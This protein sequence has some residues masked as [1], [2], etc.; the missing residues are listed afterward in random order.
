MG[1]KTVPSRC[2]INITRRLRRLR[3]GLWGERLD[4]SKRQQQQTEGGWIH[5]AEKRTYLLAVINA[6]MYIWF[7]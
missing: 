1:T 5:L 4:L 3:R 7:L 2:N 6:E